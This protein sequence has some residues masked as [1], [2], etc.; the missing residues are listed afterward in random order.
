MQAVI[1]KWGNSLEL[2]LPSSVLTAAGFEL[3]QRVNLVVAYGC[4]EIQPANTVT[5]SLD[6]LLSG[7][8][9]ENSHGEVSHGDPVGKE[10]Y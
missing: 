1:R 2:R 3:G 4:I 10:I 7:V 8:T 5:Y 6:K 9:K